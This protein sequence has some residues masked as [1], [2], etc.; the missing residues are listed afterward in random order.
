MS[1]DLGSEV[2]SEPVTHYLLGHG[3]ESDDVHEEYGDALVGGGQAAQ[4]GIGAG[5]SA[6]VADH[7]LDHM[8]RKHLLGCGLRGYWEG[9]GR[10]FHVS[11]LRCN[12][13][14]HT[15]EVT[16]VKRDVGMCWGTG[17]GEL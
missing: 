6:A 7:V 17:R 11:S 8:P 2:W 10:L 1:R 14:H 4:G 5:P 16:R 12:I 3:G 9:T 15:W 13:P